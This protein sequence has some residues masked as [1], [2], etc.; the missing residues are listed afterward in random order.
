MD[1]LYY[2]TR[3]GLVF[4]VEYAS[5]ALVDVA[6]WDRRQLVYA[7]KQGMIV[8]SAPPAV[9]QGPGIT[10]VAD[11]VTGAPVYTVS[12]PASAEVLMDSTIPASPL[13]SEDQ[14]DWLYQ[15]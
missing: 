13:Y 2:A 1:G 12:P 7:L 4:D 3:D 10:V 6:D 14:S 5:Q 11:P 9:V 8:G 15:G